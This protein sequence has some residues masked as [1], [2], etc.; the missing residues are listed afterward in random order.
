MGELDRGGTSRALSRDARTPAIDAGRVIYSNRLRRMLSGITNIAVVLVCTPRGHV[1]LGTL[2]APP[3][4]EIPPD[5]GPSGGD[6][7]DD[8]GVIA[9]SGLRPGET[10]AL[11]DYADTPPGSGRWVPFNYTMSDGTAD[12]LFLWLKR[13]IGKVT[14]ANYLA[15]VWRVLREDCLAEAR[16]PHTA[17]S[18]QALLWL[19]AARIDVAVLVVGAHG[20]IL[21]RNEAARAMMEEGRVLSSGRDGVDAAD[22]LQTRRL[23]EEIARCAA[24]GAARAETTLFLEP[25]DGGPH[26]PCTLSRFVREGVPSDLVVLTLPSP[27]NPRRVETLARGLG[28]TASE[29]RVA[30]LLQ[31]GLSNREAARLAGLTEQS[32]STYA[33]RAMHKLNVGSRAQMAQML[34]WQ[35]HGT[36]IGAHPTDA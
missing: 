17:L 15:L 3:N 18:E 33:K 19:V 36:G 11:L 30:A 21:K 4:R 13:G 25:A 14:A 22:D 10:E 9:A 16:S 2:P 20:A 5:T 26:V 12:R 8:A 28:L 31:L 35:A 24:T 27:P 7:A 34:T 23:R 6:R 32:L 1:A 29:A